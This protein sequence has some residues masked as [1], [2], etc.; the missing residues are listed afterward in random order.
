M[1]KVHERLPVKD[2]EKP[3]GI[4]QKNICV[5]S[6]KIA[7]PLCGRDQR[8]NAVKTEYFIKGTEPRDDDLCTVHVEAQVCTESKDTMNRNLLAGPYCPPDKVESKVFIQRTEPYVPV[9]PDEKA[10]KDIAYELP[11][12]EYCTVH[13]EPLEPLEPEDTINLPFW[14]PDLIRH[15]ESGDSNNGNWL[16]PPRQPHTDLDTDLDTDPDTDTDYL[17]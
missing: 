11:A 15:E 2:F 9:K 12:G 7:T 6:G 13:G 4:V 16:Q 8:G 10:P 3:T 5:Y 14:P 1:K 17:P